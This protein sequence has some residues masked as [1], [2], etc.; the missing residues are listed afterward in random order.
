MKKGSGGLLKGLLAGALVVG[1]MAVLSDAALAKKHKPKNHGEAAAVG[2]TNID[3]CGKLSADKRDACIS[4]SRPVSGA[5][6]YSK[7]GAKS[8]VVP[9][10]KAKAKA[11][12]GAVAAAATAAAGKVKAKMAAGPTSIDDCA[13]MDAGARDSCISRSRPVSGAEL[14]KKYK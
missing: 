14:Y 9:A 6:L 3:D 5:A 2:T 12:A 1:G 10:M 4:R 13:K 7:W 8:E 11:A